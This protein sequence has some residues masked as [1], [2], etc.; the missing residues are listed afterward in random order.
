VAC[1]FCLIGLGA[2]VAIKAGTPTP[3]PNMGASPEQTTVGTGFAQDGL[4]KAD[5]LEVGYV[6][7]LVAVEP[8]MLVN[9]LATDDTSTR[10]GFNATAF[11]ASFNRPGSSAST[12]SQT[13][14]NGLIG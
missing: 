8:V 1:G 4:T 5:K 6:R 7:D 12:D 14:L 10:R 2:T 9:S 3:P 11:L 13:P